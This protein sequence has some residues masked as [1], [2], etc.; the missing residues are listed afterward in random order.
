MT[1]WGEEKKKMEGG[2]KRENVRLT[3]SRTFSSWA[4]PL[5]LQDNSSVPFAQNTRP[6]A[7]SCRI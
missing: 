7:S 1:G 6:A 2:W 3:V 5:L 4:E